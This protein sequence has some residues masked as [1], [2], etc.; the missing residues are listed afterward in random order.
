[1]AQREGGPFGLPFAIKPR[2]VILVVAVLVLL[3]IGTSSVYQVD[4]T[5][6]AVVLR[7]GQ[8]L[9]ITPPG[10][11]TKLPFGIDR[12][13]NVPTEVIQNMS[14]GFRTERAGAHTQYS[15]R[16][17]PDESVMLTG[18]LN[19]IDVEWI[20]Q[21]RITD[22]RA[23][24]FN[25]EHR[26]NEEGRDQTISDVSRSVINQLVGDRTIFDVIGPERTSIMVQAQEQMNELFDNFGLGIRVVQVQLQDTVPPAG[27]VQTAFQ[28]VNRA[29]QDMNRLINEGKEEYSRVIPRTQGEANR[30]VEEAKGYATRIVNEAKGDVARFLSVYEEYRKAPQVTKRRLYYEMIEDVLSGEERIDLIDRN[31]NNFIPFKSLDGQAVQGGTR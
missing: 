8:F 27:P 6:Q 13:F 18:D 2:I 28:D 10:L 14:F 20:I 31:L 25:V 22:P 5:E 19:I 7:F 26:Y 30:V 12:N 4:Q 9:K 11:H 1:M 15:S 3:Y 24:L 16:D 17:F 21:Y 23:W 29:E